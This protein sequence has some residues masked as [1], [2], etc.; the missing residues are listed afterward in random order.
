[1]EKPWEKYKTGG[2]QPAA[3]PPVQAAPPDQNERATGTLEDYAKAAGSG[4]VTGVEAT[5][6]APGDLRELAGWAGDRVGDFV[7]G[8]EER[9]RKDAKLKEMLTGSWTNNLPLNEG[10]PSS[11]QV[12]SAQRAVTGF[13]PYEPQTT[14]GQFIRTA[15]EFV[16]G[17]V[18]FGPAREGANALSNFA[19]NAMKY[20]VAPG[21]TS[22][23]AGQTARRVEPAAEPYARFAGAMAGPAIASGIRK[24]VTP[25][26]S[27][28]YA[29]AAADVLQGEGVQT[30]AGQRTGNNMMQYAESEIG[31]GRGAAF[32]DTQKE[33]FTQAVL[34]RAGIDA[35]RAT[36]EVLNDA[37]ERI[38]QQFDRLA[39]NST[40]V[41]DQ[42]TADAINRAYRDYVSLTPPNSRVPAVR[43][44]RAAIMTAPNGQLTGQQYRYIRS[45]LGRMA[46]ETAT[47]NAQ[48][49]QG[50]SAL[51][52]FMEALDDSVERTMQDPALLAQWRQA[53]N[54]YRNIL[55]IEEV[56]AGAGKD[57]TKGLVSPNR[58]RSVVSRGRNRRQYVRGQGDYGPLAR[59]GAA[60]LPEMQNSGTAPRQAVRN[61]LNATP[62]A[63]GGLL[64]YM[65]GGGDMATTLGGLA[66]GATAQAAANAAV[67]QALFGPTGRRYFAN[68]LLPAPNYSPVAGVPSMLSGSTLSLR[69]ESP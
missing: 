65:A 24:A 52:S 4:L 56:M 58:L 43:D 30:T 39:A 47:T 68:Q 7:W 61:L 46:R 11:R 22:E 51:R 26:R 35:T 25:V 60:V 13:T 9:A 27:D 14:G 49:Y 64:G 38:G 23:A 31:G 59:A 41:I 66:A 28:P 50:A 18:A 44:F 32:Y 20:G 16:P 3:S 57:A 21:V 33:Q 1:M 6:G 40:A 36:P 19:S 55:P 42:T 63:T 53:R 10:M 48:G 34:R 37:F 5:V 12:A 45:E 2:A 29:Q 8:P 69:R 15:A 67:R 17:A 54:Q 62:A